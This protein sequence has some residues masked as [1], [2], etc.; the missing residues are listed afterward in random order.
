MFVFSENYEGV[1]ICGENSEHYI[2]K[3]GRSNV[4]AQFFG[5]NEHYIYIY[6]FIVIDNN[7]YHQIQLYATFVMFVFAKKKANIAEHYRTLPNIT[8]H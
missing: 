6:I 8:E 7:T 4:D 2:R 1:K 5:K 3:K